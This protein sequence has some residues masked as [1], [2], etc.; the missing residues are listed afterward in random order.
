MDGVSC[1]WS[2]SVWC[3]FKAFVTCAWFVPSVPCALRQ[4]AWQGCSLQPAAGVGWGGTG[5]SAAGTD[6]GDVQHDAAR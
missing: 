2:S 5:C 6:Y 1:S 3:V 4:G